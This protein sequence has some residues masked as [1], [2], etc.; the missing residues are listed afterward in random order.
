MLSIR[1][2]SHDIT[3]PPVS[4]NWR[5]GVGCDGFGRD[6]IG[7]RGG[8]IVNCREVRTEVATTGGEDAARTA[9]PQRSDEDL[10]PET[11]ARRQALQSGRCL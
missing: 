4:A 9:G 1:D 5:V 8:C 6:A 11:P 3:N 10:P 7:R 2:E